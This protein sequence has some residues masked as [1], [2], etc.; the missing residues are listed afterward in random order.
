ML[1]SNVCGIA[2]SPDAIYSHSHWID[3]CS[4]REVR[5][6]MLERSG[7]VARLLQVEG[8]GSNICMIKSSPGCDAIHGH[9]H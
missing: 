1:G 4:S 6:S 3:V 9:M 5:E 2:S 8:L 7:M